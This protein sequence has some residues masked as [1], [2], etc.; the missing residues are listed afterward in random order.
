MVQYSRLLSHLVFR[1][2][3]TN[4]VSS[5]RGE[6][7]STTKGAPSL[8]MSA[9]VGEKYQLVTELDA[10][11]VAGN[12]HAC[13]RRKTTSR[14]LVLGLRAKQRNF[15]VGRPADLLGHAVGALLFAG[16]ARWARAGSGSSGGDCS[17][18][19]SLRGDA[20]LRCNCR[21]T[22]A[23]ALGKTTVDKTNPRSF[24]TAG[25]SARKLDA[26]LRTGLGSG[27]ITAARGIS[28]VA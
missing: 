14:T 22:W 23:R 2:A 12:G 18:G 21:A 20:A 17:S 10:H 5:A 11:L 26:G 9:D 3:R 28:A 16:K 24:G 25:T 13:R 7:Q 6:S 1:R 4:G 8:A 27:S 15:G 19:S